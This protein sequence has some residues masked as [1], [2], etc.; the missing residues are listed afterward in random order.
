[1]GATAA[2]GLVAGFFTLSGGTASAD[3]VSLTQKY[4]CEFPIIG[5][6]PITINI[7]ME[8]PKTMK[9]GEAVPA[10]PV[11]AA[12]DVS[13]RA[14]KGITVATGKT[15][16]GKATATVDVHRPQIEQPLKIEVPNTVEK[17]TIPSPAAAFTVNSTGETP[18]D[19]LTWTKPGIASFDVKG[20]TLHDMIARNAAGEP[21]DLDAGE[22][23][24]DGK[25]DTFKAPCTLDPTSPVKIAEMDIVDEGG[26]TPGG[27][28]EGNTTGN[29]TNGGTGD[30]KLGT[31]VKDGGTPGGTLSMKQAGDA[32]ALSAVE[33]GKGGIS[34]GNLNAVTVS[35]TRTGP[36]AW[37]L[38]GKV[39]DFTGT[40]GTI[41]GDKLSWKPT[42]ETAAG[43]AS[44][45]QPGT[46]GPVGTAGAT[47]ASAPTG[48]KTGG[49]FTAGAGLN[50]DVPAE[51]KTGTYSSV[52]TLTLT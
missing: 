38:V 49:T 26:G 31:E 10:F 52:L 35:D 29:T 17:T 13:V 12:T 47:L 11:K 51:A 23:H 3:T 43:S 24:D 32:V 46:E 21:V 33:Q 37:S 1:M 36:A 6:D 14:A 41:P 20:I 16:E 4:S 45:C 39:T 40:A 27:T 19:L 18:G 15:L 48:E 44:T 34:S 5:A 50:L 22:P 42:C 7:E 9:V 25:P 8:L 28:V 30:Q 2:A